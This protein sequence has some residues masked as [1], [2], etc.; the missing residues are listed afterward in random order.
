[1]TANWN[2]LGHEW[3]VDMLRQHVARSA[4]RHAYLFSGPPGLGR[5]TLALRL[6]QALNCTHPTAPG[7]ACWACRDCRQ[8]ESMQ[9]PDLTIIQAEAEGGTLKVDQVR[10][11]RRTVNLKPYQSKYRLALFLRFQEANDN[12]SNALLKT[13]EEAPAHAILILTADHPEQLLPTIVSR[14]EVLRLRPLPVSAIEADLK[15]RGLEADRAR[16]LAHLSGGRPGYARRLAGDPGLLEKREEH[17]NDLQTL[18]P[19]SRVDK[20]AYAEKLA[21]DKESMRQA[22]LNW[23][24]YW[25]DVL[26][27]AAQAET[28]ISNLDRNMEIEFLAGKLNLADARRVMHDLELA[29]ERLERNVNARLVAEVLLLDWP[30]M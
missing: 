17:L 15:K 7:E 20:F 3:A 1:M 22:L 5:R 13:L 29:L 18:L 12:A 8:I 4:A 9:H 6:A 25:H 24:S 21:R 28:P 14:C 27:R 2:M 30:R 26:L 16:L 23:L 10:E 19:A 11:L